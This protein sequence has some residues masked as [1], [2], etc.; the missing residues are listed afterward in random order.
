MH[1]K[2]QVIPGKARLYAAIV[3]SKKLSKTTNFDQ[4]DLSNLNL[5]LEDS[6]PYDCE[7][8]QIDQVLGIEN[9]LLEIDFND[10]KKKILANGQNATGMKVLKI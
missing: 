4:L 9:I 1:E 10:I 5:R 8:L 3:K 6:D 7:K 2:S